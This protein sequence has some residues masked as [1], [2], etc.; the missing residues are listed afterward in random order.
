[1][2][3]FRKIII[4]LILVIFFSKISAQVSFGVKTGLNLSLARYLDESKNELIKPH[5]KLK[6]GLVAGVFANISLNK[7]LS[8]QTDLLY[9][10]KGLKFIQEAYNNKVINTMNYIEVPITG[11]YKIY[12]SKYNFISVYFGGYV[13][14][15]TDGKYKSISLLTGESSSE[16]VNFNSEFYSY[17]RFD[18]GLLGGVS[19]KLG[20]NVGIDLRYTHS[21]LSSSQ[22]YA[23]GISNSVISLF[24]TYCFFNKK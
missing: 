20:S 16:N 17:S 8:I 5:R 21:K 3:N 10:Q 18:A 22:E 11:N 14:F 1:M 4:A 15:W 12:F 24:L 13:A 7:I 6:P 19:Y 9:S 23:D 2:L